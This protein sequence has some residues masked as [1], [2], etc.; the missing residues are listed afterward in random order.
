MESRYGINF[1]ELGPQQDFFANH[2]YAM[3][4]GVIFSEKAYTCMN[5]K[6]DNKNFSSAGNLWE[7]TDRLK[8]VE[9][10]FRIM[11]DFCPQMELLLPKWRA[12]WTLDAIRKTGV[13]I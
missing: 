1:A 9:D 2:L 6:P 12:W 4:H 5:I 8:M 10:K 11:M 3:N 7:M 13:K